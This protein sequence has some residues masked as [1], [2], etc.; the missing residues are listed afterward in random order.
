MDK[1]KT[2]EYKKDEYCH[3]NYDKWKN[4]LYCMK[5]NCSLYETEEV[6]SK[7]VSKRLAV[8][9][10]DKT[11]EAC[12]GE[13]YIVPDPND[14]VENC[15]HCNGTG[16]EPKIKSDSE[17]KPDQ[18][19]EVR[20]AYL[21]TRPIGFSPY[22]NFISGYKSALSASEKQIEELQANIVKTIIEKAKQ[23]VEIR[24]YKQLSEDNQDRVRAADIRIKELEQQ[25][26]K[27]EY[28][29]KYH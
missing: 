15:P 17:S 20:K 6:I 19:S 7:S 18:E 21:S 4:V 5:E 25:I 16:K 11:C 9:N 26:E 3:N 13:G 22:D 8:Q 1:D 2:C 29:N 14:Y 12:K 24:E 28:K 10:K 23:T 27:L